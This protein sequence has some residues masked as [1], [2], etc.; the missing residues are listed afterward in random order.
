MEEMDKVAERNF[1]PREYKIFQRVREQERLRAFYNC[2]TRKE[3]FIKAIGEGLSF[4]LR[5]FEVS[6]EPDRPAELITVHGGTDEARNWAMHDLKTRDGYTA[7]VVV[8]GS[9]HSISH[10][11]W[12]YTQ[13]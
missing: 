3:A 7:A 4:P 5:V 1:S 10:K 6:F 11:Q 13:F 9:D 12:T 8:E 2:W